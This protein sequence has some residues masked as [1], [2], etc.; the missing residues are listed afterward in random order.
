MSKQ[1]ILTDLI[2]LSHYLGEES[3]E[4][5]IIGEGNTSARIDD[6]TFW[7]KASGSNLRTIDAAGFVEVNSARVLELLE[8]EAADED[9]TRVLMAARVE[10]ETAGR[11]SVETVLHAVLYELTDALWIGHTHPIAANIVL[12]SAH[13]SEITRH[14]MPDAVVV[15]GPHMIFVPYT[16][17]GVPLTREV[18]RRVQQFIETFDEMPRVVWLQ[19]HGLFALGQTPRQVENVT[20]MAVKH[21]R[22][23]AG[24]RTLGEPHWLSEHDIARLHTRPDEEVRRAKFR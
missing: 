16:D 24:V 9:T 20:Q 21:A 17:P 13:A 4:Y 23:L 6:A 15:C 19:N 5:V 10:P 11:P 22:V 7:V 2:G 8:G 18:H 3:R 1:S 12:C 14:V